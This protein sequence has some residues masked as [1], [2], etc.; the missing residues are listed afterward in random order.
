VLV[1]LLWVYYS[2]QILLVGAEFTRIYADRARGPVPPQSFAE[3]VENPTAAG[4][5]AA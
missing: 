4:T 5:P 1:L 2:S 3:V